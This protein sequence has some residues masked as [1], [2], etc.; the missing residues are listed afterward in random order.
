MLANASPADSAGAATPLPGSQGSNATP[1]VPHVAAST[2]GNR[3]APSSSHPSASD[4]PSTSAAAPDGSTPDIA[5]GD[6]PSLLPSV[7]NKLQKWGDYEAMGGPIASTR[8]V[9]MKTPLSAAIL[10]SWSAPGELRH[11]L[12]VPEML[13]AQS[14]A[15]RTV[16][17][18]I[19]LSNHDCLYADDIPPHLRYV[20]PGLE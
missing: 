3:E 15:G 10:G 20:H 14:A 8:F 11:R 2:S 16:G 1:A 13:A 7:L 6:A 17:L 5:D 19:D 9:P 12:T 18:V 4:G